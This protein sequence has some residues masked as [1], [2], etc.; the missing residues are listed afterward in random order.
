MDECPWSNVLEIQSAPHSLSNHG[1][2]GITVHF[3]KRF[4]RIA[5]FDIHISDPSFFLPR[6]TDTYLRRAKI[7]DVFTANAVLNW[8]RKCPGIQPFHMLL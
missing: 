1:S 8:E 5:V 6:V 2:R 4:G 3:H 7:R